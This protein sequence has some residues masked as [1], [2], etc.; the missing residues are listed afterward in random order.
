MDAALTNP[1]VLTVLFGAFGGAFVWLWTQVSKALQKHR[2]CEVE[3]A[4][5]RERMAAQDIE[6]GKVQATCNT[7][8]ELLRKEIHIG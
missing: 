8:T 1:A 3:L 5:L 6:L 2:E 7:L 4:Q